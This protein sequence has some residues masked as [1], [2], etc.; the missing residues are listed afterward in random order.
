MNQFS[1]FY[2][3]KRKRNAAIS[4][5]CKPA[6]ERWQSS[7]AAAN[8]E[9]EKQKG[10]YDHAKK[11]GEPTFIANAVMEMK[12]AKKEAMKELDTLGLFKSDLVPVL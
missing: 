6:V 7:H 11:L 10:L 3:V 1:E 9:F 12:E 8:V 5:I 4:H 2:F